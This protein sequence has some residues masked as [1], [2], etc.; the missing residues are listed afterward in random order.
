ML[1]AADLWAVMVVAVIVIAALTAWCLV[2]AFL[3][4]LYCRVMHARNE[5]DAQTAADFGEPSRDEVEAG[6]DGPRAMWGPLNDAAADADWAVMLAAVSLTPEQVATDY[7]RT[8]LAMRM[9]SIRRFMAI[10]RE[11]A[12]FRDELDREAS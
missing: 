12:A 4:V 3:A 10:E 8:R 1:T 6:F 11:V 2:S 7:Q 5:A 9:D